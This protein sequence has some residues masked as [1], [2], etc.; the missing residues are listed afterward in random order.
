MKGVAELV[1][2]TYYTI[3]RSIGNGGP[4]Y[5]THRPHKLFTFGLS[6]VSILVII[7]IPTP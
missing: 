5:N 7:I 1:K 3:V 4:T 2:A 6:E